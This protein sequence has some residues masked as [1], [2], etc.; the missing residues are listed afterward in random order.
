MGLERYSQQKQH[1]TGKIRFQFLI[2]R[3]PMFEIREQL[4]KICT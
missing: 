4:I 1:E 3:K 2:V